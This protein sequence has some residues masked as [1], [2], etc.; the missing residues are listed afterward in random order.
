M[1]TVVATGPLLPGVAEAGSGDQATPGIQPHHPA[2]ATAATLA[3]AVRGGSAAGP[4]I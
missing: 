1:T 2:V 3:S 4:A